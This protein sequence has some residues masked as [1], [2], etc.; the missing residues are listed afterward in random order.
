MEPLL[1]FVVH[2]TADQAATFLRRAKNLK[3]ESAKDCRQL[4]QEIVQ[5]VNSHLANGNV[6]HALRFLRGETTTEEQRTAKPCSKKEAND[7]ATPPTVAAA[8]PSSAVGAVAAPV[9][10]VAPPIAANPPPQNADAGNIG[11]GVRKPWSQLCSRERRSRALVATKPFSNVFWTAFVEELAAID[12]NGNSLSNNELFAIMLD[13]GINNATK[14]NRLAPGLTFPECLPD[15]TL[16]SL[17]DK[18]LADKA[19]EDYCEYR[20]E[21]LDEW[22]QFYHK[23]GN[24][25]WNMLRKL[26]PDW[27]MPSLYQMQN[28]RQEME[29]HYAHRMGWKRTFSGFAADIQEFLPVYTLSNITRAVCGFESR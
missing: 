13:Y 2:F 26:L 24:D 15:R 27:M 7:N 12:D 3:L 11:S 23:V 6:K 28:F 21:Q 22:F 25:A 18:W 29:L 8:A 5:D 4:T 16:R 20:Q 17:R 19:D 1:S 10:A 14:K 9:G